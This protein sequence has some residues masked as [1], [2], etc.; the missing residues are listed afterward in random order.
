VRALLF[1]APFLALVG[2]G[3]RTDLGTP[4]RTAAPIDGGP[5]PLDAAA[6]A[7]PPDAPPPD[8]PPSDAA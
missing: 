6:D 5:A 7:P 3:A 1:L 8:A 2:C 4:E